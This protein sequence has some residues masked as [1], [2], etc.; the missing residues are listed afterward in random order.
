MHLK[1]QHQQDLVLLAKTGDDAGWMAQEHNGQDASD[2]I[3]EAEKRQMN[4]LAR[5]NEELAER[6]RVGG[7][8]VAPESFEHAVCT[9][10]DL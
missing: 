1:S 6:C 5:D 3:D 10:C 8:I 4:A 7:L 2:E 9:H